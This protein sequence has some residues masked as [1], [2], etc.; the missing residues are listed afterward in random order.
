MLMKHVC[1]T[2]VGSDIDCSPLD[3]LE[4]LGFEPTFVIGKS[5]AWPHISSF[6][7]GLHPSTHM[8]VKISTSA[9]TSS[10]VHT[11]FVCA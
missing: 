4:G 1:L 9:D 3:A 10:L 11:Y 8:C 2:N 5:S 7:R 6:R